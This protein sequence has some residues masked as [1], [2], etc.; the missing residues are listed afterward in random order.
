MKMMGMI[1]GQK[2]REEGGRIANQNLFCSWG[3]K[4]RMNE[5]KEIGANNIFLLLGEKQ[6]KR[7]KTEGGGEDLGEEK[8]NV[9]GKGDGMGW[10]IFDP[11]KMKGTTRRGSQ[12]VVVNEW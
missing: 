6:E 10:S 2:F 4:A 12:F 3:L 7:S 5:R 9:I 8:M 11:G 1:W